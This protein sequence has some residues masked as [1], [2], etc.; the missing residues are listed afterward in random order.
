M[1]MGLCQSVLLHKQVLSVHG[2]MVEN[3]LYPL[4]TSSCTFFMLKQKQMLSEIEIKRRK[5]PFINSPHKNDLYFIASLIQK[6]HGSLG[7]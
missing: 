4:P 6:S 7:Q 2:G 1:T 5:T 3:F